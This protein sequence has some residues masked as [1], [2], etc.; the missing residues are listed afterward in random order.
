MFMA[1]FALKEQSR[2]VATETIWPDILGLQRNRTNRKIYY[3]N[4][5]R[6]L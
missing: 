3:R 6:Q 4:W 5:L 2:V 1:A